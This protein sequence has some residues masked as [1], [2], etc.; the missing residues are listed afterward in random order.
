MLAV[1]AIYAIIDLYMLITGSP[2]STRD[3]LIAKICGQGQVSIT[4]IRALLTGLGFS[5]RQVG[6]HI[7]FQKGGYRLTIP[8]SGQV[9]KV[10]LSQLCDILR[11][12][13]L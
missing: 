4:E 5:S 7:T 3:K 1:I 12:L 8:A 11:G 9:K 10:Y 13:A 2:V 6:S